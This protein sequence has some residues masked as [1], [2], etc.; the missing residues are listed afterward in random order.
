[1][2]WGEGQMGNVYQ[3]AAAGL[4]LIAAHVAAGPDEIVIY[5]TIQGDPAN[6]FANSFASSLRPSA[7]QRRRKPCSQRGWIYS[8]EHARRYVELTEHD[9]QTRRIGYL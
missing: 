2:L 9:A 6:T 1:M 4:L 3:V 5:D 7:V 8:S